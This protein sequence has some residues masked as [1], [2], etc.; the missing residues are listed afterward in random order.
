M[1]RKKIVLLSCVFVLFV[2]YIFQL[3]FSDKGKIKE[4]S[5]KEKPNIVV[6]Q[7][8]TETIEIIKNENEWSLANKVPAKNDLAEYLSS[9]CTNLKIIETVSK[10]SS[11]DELIKYGLDKPIVVT[12]FNEQ[13]QI[14]KLLIGKEAM[15]QNQCYVQIEGK[16]EVYLVS[17]NL[18]SLFG[19]TQKELLDLTLY[20]V[21]TDDVY[22]VQVESGNENFSIE[23]AGEIA[24]Y[25]WNIVKSNDGAKDV[26]AKLDSQKFQ[27]WV[28]T[29]IEL[30]V[31]SWVEDFNSID[32]VLKNQPTLK[33]V[34]G[35]AGKDIIVRFF[36][37]DNL[38]ICACSENDF[39][40]V[41][42]I[43]DFNKFN[44]VL[45]DFVD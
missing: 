29:I 24:D 43:D 40:C 31:E 34:L 6:I 19:I 35:A 16:K 2:V 9:A 25:K 8:N 13:K 7:N 10:K 33:V 5:T 21:K 36:K 45:S 32:S 27:T 23:K 44:V 37:T 17:E 18:N 14:Q 12:A 30:N 26:S 42:S 20:S 1:T 4:L 15:T 28:N 11:D 3:I 41:V 22:K 39:P 38:V